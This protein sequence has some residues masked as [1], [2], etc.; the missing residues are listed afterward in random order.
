M[1]PNTKPVLP[2]APARSWLLPIVLCALTLAGGIM[3]PRLLLHP[4][5]SAE[6]AGVKS[7][8]KIEAKTATV[9]PSVSKETITYEPPE[10]PEP[11]DISGMLT[12]LMVG[13]AVVLGLCTATLWFIKRRMGTSGGQRSGNGRL[14]LLESLS[15]S[16]RASL[17]LLQCGSCRVVVGLDAGGI[18][19]AILLEQPFEQSLANVESL[20]HAAAA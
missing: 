17:H 4:A 6:T 12:R 3:L 18:K 13:T 1:A 8:T 15:L 7:E 5:N 19:S 16:N 11:P 20:E 2:R 9:A 10:L 14:H